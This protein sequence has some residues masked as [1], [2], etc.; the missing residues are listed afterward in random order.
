M[1]GGDH[2]RQVP[3]S[4]STPSTNHHLNSTQLPTTIIS[5]TQPSSTQTQPMTH[6]SSAHAKTNL[7]TSPLFTPNPNEH[8]KTLETECASR[9]LEE[10][11]RSQPT[12]T[13]YSLGCQLKIMTITLA[14]TNSRVSSTQCSTSRF[15]DHFTYNKPP[16]SP[17][18]PTSALFAR[19][20]SS[21]VN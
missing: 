17:K 9:S 20:S 14:S 15:F 16:Q 11:K 21:F 8:E 2:F 12:I 4:S 6:T 13:N 3:A 1:T 18:A 7:P 10:S 19:I 5:H